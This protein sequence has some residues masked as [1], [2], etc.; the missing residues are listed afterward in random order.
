M[1]VKG[2]TSFG[3]HTRPACNQAPLEIFSLN[4]HSDFHSKYSVFLLT[5]GNARG[6]GL[7]F[8]C[9]RMRSRSMRKCAHVNAG[10]LG[11][12]LAVCAC[13][14]D[15]IHVTAQGQRLGENCACVP[16]PHT[17]KL[18]VCVFFTP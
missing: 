9:L 8:E 18:C 6:L 11:S 5:S 17:V 13:A 1:H 15:P 12:I 3:P 4:Q 16:T 14:Y 10:G 7:L 2:V